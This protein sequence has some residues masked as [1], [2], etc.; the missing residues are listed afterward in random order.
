[1]KTLQ[2][3]HVVVG[4]GIVT[5]FIIGGILLNISNAQ[6]VPTVLVE[7]DGVTKIE[8]LNARITIP[9]DEVDNM[10]LE[11]VQARIVTVTDKIANCTARFSAELVELQAIEADIQSQIII[12][13]P[14]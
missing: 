13:P 2:T 1:M 7:D 8:E 12:L 4:A 10:S 3:K 5:S 9:R 6:G 14:R 11:D